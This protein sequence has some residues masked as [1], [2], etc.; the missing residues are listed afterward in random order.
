MADTFPS[1]YVDQKTGRIESFQSAF[2][3]LTDEGV[4]NLG[5]WALQAGK[6]AVLAPFIGG[7][8]V[9][10][11]VAAGLYFGGRYVMQKSLNALH[12]RSER[13]G[14]PFVEYDFT[15]EN[16]RAMFRKIHGKSHPGFADDLL[17][18]VKMSELGEVPKV[19]VMMPG[20]GTE[21]FVCSAETRPDGTAPIVTLG[22]GAMATLDP[23]EMR[24]VVGHELTHVKLGHIKSGTEWLSRGTLSMVLNTALV[25]VALFAGA[26]VL[27][28]LAFVAITNVVGKCLRSV[29][30]RRHEE[31]CDKGS[32]LLTGETKAL[33]SALKKIHKGLLYRHQQEVDDKYLRK[34]EIPPKVEEAGGI[35]QFLFGTHPTLARRE[36]LLREF[37]ENHKSYC[38]KKRAEF[39]TVFN[40]AAAPASK[41]QPV[42]VVRP[43][44]ATPPKLKAA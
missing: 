5:H 26:P 17:R 23:V 40:V 13:E 33:T 6:L 15:Q 28:V 25:G 41:P 34:G 7:M 3:K 18:M 19:R 8:A 22:R 29:Q 36:N 30:S 10:L 43:K 24:A 12:D 42:A 16:D 38:E 44:A 9:A 35:Q 21:D 39:R 37:E 1:G 14:G 11:P 4:P 20:Q 32:A 27:P 2:S 31:M